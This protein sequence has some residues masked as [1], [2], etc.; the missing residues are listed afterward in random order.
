MAHASSGVVGVKLTLSSQ[1]GTY[2]RWAGNGAGQQDMVHCAAPRHPLIPNGPRQAD[3]IVYVPSPPTAPPSACAF[4]HQP[5][6]SLVYT[7]AGGLA[8]ISDTPSAKPVG[9]LLLRI[10]RRGRD[11]RRHFY[12][13]YPSSSLTVLDPL[14]SRIHPPP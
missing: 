10:V 9:F 13:S 14:P 3:D 11:Q 1:K 2:Q 6:S 4:P 7:K 12:S 5:T 8:Y